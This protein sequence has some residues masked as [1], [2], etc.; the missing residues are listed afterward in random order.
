MDYQQIGQILQSVVI[1]VGALSIL[2]GLRGVTKQVQVVTYLEFTKRYSQ[3]VGPMLKLS[4]KHKSAQCLADIH[5]DEAEEFR[6]LAGGYFAILA[7]EYHLYKLGHL[8][9]RT[10]RMWSAL[11]PNILRNPLMREVWNEAQEWYGSFPEFQRFIDAQFR[12]VS[13]T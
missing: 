13:G 7:H 8:D 1:I 2:T 6:D 9:A 3:I 5:A 10:W 12:R 11:V 4:R